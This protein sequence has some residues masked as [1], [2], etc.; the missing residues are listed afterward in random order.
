MNTVKSDWCIFLYQI[1]KGFFDKDD[2]L[3]TEFMAVADQLRE[4]H[5]FAHT[6]SEEVMAELGHREYGFF[7]IL[8]INIIY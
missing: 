4:S 8:F 5:S 2:D 3:Q 1:F 7:S 6:A